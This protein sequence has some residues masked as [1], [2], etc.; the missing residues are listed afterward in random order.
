MTRLRVVAVLMLDED[1]QPDDDIG[2]VSCSSP[3]PAALCLCPEVLMEVN[4]ALSIFMMASAPVT[5]TTLL[6][7][8][9]DASLDPWEHGGARGG[10]MT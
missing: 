2:A 3:Q 10:D 9:E 1:L 7:E 4:N 8:V 6:P 5:I